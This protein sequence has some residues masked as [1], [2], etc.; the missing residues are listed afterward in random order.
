MVISGDKGRVVIGWRRL[1]G[2]SILFPDSGGGF[3]SW[4]SHFW[5]RTIF[6]L[7]VVLSG[8]TW[9][10]SVGGWASLEDLRCL[11]SHIFWKD[12]AHL[13]SCPY[14]CGLSRRVAGILGA[15]RVSVPKDRRWELLVLARQG[16]ETSISS[17]LSSLQ[18]SRCTQVQGEET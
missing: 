10:Y 17:M 4:K 18:Q 14:P 13:G 1:R 15:P 3:T 8:V 12:W 9:C 7:Q 16:L 2:F 11:K 6:L 5:S